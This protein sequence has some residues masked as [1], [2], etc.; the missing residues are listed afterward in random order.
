MIQLII[1]QKIVDQ[2]L[3][4]GKKIEIIFSTLFNATDV[5]KKFPDDF[6]PEQ[7]TLMKQIY[8]LAV[9]GSEVG[10]RVYKCS[11][12][13]AVIAITGYTR[14]EPTVDG[15]MNFPVDDKI[16]L[17][18]SRHG[19][20]VK[21]ALL[22]IELNESFN[23]AHSALLETIGIKVNGTGGNFE[24]IEFTGDISIGVIKNPTDSFINMGDFKNGKLII[25]K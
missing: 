5:I 25:Q 3:M 18:F 19:L 10:N 4:E 9:Y 23:E 7:Q 12:E 17:E 20:D 24:I 1:D 11:N 16:T 8:D 2:Q 13:G 6:T 21:A 22:E 15:I 14:I